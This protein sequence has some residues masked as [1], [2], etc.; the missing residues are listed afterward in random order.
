VTTLACRLPMATSSEAMMSQ[1][2]TWLADIDRD[3]T[4]MFHRRTLWREL[5][6]MLEAT[7]PTDW[8]F[9]NAFTRLYGDSQVM[10]VRRQAGMKSGVHSLARLIDQLRR[11]PTFLTRKRFIAM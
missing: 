6:G 5:M 1:W 4:L 3:T 7:E 2:R 11:H 10:G 9:G 8:T